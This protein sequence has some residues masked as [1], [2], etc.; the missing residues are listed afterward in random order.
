V[1]QVEEVPA[2]DGTPAIESL[3][4]SKADCDAWQEILFGV[5]QKLPIWKERN[6]QR[7]G[8]APEDGL[9]LEDEDADLDDEDADLE[10]RD[11]ADTQVA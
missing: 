9:G 3:G 7:H 5:L 2:D 11:A 8:L 1:K 4:A 6:T 10:E